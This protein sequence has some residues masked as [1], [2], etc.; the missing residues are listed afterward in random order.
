MIDRKA[1]ILISVNAIVLSVLLG[2]SYLNTVAVLASGPSVAT[3]LISCTLSVLTALIAIKP[4]LASHVGKDSQLL[5]FEGAK[6]M[7]FST[8]RKSVKKTIKKENRIYDTMIADIYS[9]SKN[10][11][12]KHTYLMVSAV[13]FG[14]GI[15]AAVSSA[16][17]A[18]I[19]L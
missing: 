13:L 9:V 17:V 8:F 19:T 11:S 2:S 7:D 1:H 12:K 3:L 5:S 18:N 10:I 6:N 4:G 14:I 15:L 16:I